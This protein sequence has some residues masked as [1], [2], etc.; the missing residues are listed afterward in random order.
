MTSAHSAVPV[1]STATAAPDPLHRLRDATAALHRRLDSALPLA[2]PGAG[3]TDYLRHLALLRGW[4]HMLHSAGAASARLEQERD[5]L[6][7]E[8]AECEQLLDQPVPRLRGT[9]TPQAVFQMDGAEWG[10]AYVLEGSRLGGQV[11]YK[12]LA[13]A[14]APLP[15]TYLRGAGSATGVRW[16][17]FIAELG[18]ALDSEVRVNAAACAAARAFELLLQCHEA[19]SA[20][21][22]GAT[23][24]PA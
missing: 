11:L 19:L 2:H 4:I 21:D 12:R 17:A 13:Q 6:D 5:A 7:A 10:L 24:A 15:L 9:V 14:M 23:A 22:E 1:P 16:K 8:L 3:P 18:A 20:G